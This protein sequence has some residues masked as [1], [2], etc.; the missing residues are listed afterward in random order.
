MLG[1]FLFLGVYFFD[2]L[3]V[4]RQLKLVNEVVKVVGEECDDF[5]VFLKD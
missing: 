2:F 1:S 3:E 4:G 5:L